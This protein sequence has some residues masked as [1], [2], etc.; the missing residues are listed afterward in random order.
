M[1]TQ[2]AMKAQ[3]ELAARR[4]EYMVGLGRQSVFRDTPTLSPCAYRA[5]AVYS[6]ARGCSFASGGDIVERVSQNKCAA[7]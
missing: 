5:P 4:C 1:H 6:G 7:V 3:R 2:A